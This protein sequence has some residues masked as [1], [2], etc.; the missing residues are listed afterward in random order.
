MQLH[1]IIVFSLALLTATAPA[2]A[3]S[4]RGSEQR[5]QQQGQDHQPSGSGVLRLLPSDSVSEHALDTPQGKLNYT[6][7]AGT[8]PLYGQSGEQI[9]AIFYTSYVAK[10]AGDKRPLTFAFNGGP[11][12]ASAFLNL[13]LVG[14][15]RLD[16]G[17]DARN[18]SD[19]K[20][21]DN[22]DSWLRF[23][24]LVLIDPIG[25]GWSR[26]AK[27][28]AAPGPPLKAKVSGRLSPAFFAT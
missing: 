8:I 20:L 5:Q 19:A 11:G 10:N 17:A 15:R 14:P 12:A 27:A 4:N 26:T 3:Q 21:V 25:T 24:D 23:T 18:P 13:G 6:A 1:R 16:L 2:L 22:P 9:A 28:D 7:T